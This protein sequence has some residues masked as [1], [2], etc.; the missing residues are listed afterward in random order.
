MDWPIKLK[1]RWL[2]LLHALAAAALVLPGSARAQG[3]LVITMPASQSRAS[4]EA[5]QPA[6]ITVERASDIAGAPV[7]FSRTIFSGVPLA[8]PVALPMAASGL[9]VAGHL[10]SRF[11]PRFHPIFGMRLQHHGV[12]VAA[13]TGTPIIATADGTVSRAGWSGG[14]GLL[15]ALDHGRGMETRFGHMSRIL[16]QPGARV[17][18]GTILG[19]VGSTGNS[20]GPHVHYEVRVNGVAVDPQ[21]AAAP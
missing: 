10:T 8:A 7:R 2:L 1:M 4:A 18:R 13:A 14:Y 21:R 19:Y 6:V 17:Q 3:A 12:D 20:T 9:P 11:G 16:V 5:T 15:V